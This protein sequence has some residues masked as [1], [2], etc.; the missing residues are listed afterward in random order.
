MLKLAGLLLLVAGTLAGAVLIRPVSRARFT[1]RIG[2][3]LLFPFGVL[4]GVVLIALGSSATV[5]RPSS[6]PRA[7]SSSPWPARPRSFWSSRRSE[8]SV[9]PGASRPSGS[10][11]SSRR[12]PEDASSPP[13]KVRPEGVGGALRP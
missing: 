4:A 6:T 3:W 11:W 2:T 10:S 7:A 1:P 13:P 5:C 9:R 12:S 8:P